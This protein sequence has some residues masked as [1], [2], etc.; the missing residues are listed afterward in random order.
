MDK[1]ITNPSQGSDLELA[2][3][4]ARRGDSIKRKTKTAQ[5]RQQSTHTSDKETKQK[6]SSI[7]D[8]LNENKN[9]RIMLWL[10]WKIKDQRFRDDTPNTGIVNE[11]FVHWHVH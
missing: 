8:L 9:K 3:L 11:A 2:Q 10:F 7:D 5:L 4:R 6:Q 1:N